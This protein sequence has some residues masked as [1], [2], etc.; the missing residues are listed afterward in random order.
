M[1]FRVACGFCLSLEALGLRVWGFGM[2]DWCFKGLVFFF[3]QFRSFDGGYIWHRIRSS[4]LVLWLR[5]LDYCNVLCFFFE[6]THTHANIK[7]LHRT[8]RHIIF[9]P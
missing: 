2:R 5:E 1:G 3:L 8:H 4:D 7:C 6:H 9:S